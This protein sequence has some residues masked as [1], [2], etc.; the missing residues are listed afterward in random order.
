MT[1]K[2]NQLKRIIQMAGERYNPEIE[3]IPDI[4]SQENNAG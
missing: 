4:F 1:P 2:N 3:K